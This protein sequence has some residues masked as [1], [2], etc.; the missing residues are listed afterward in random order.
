MNASVLIVDDNPINLKL[1]CEV[2]ELGGFSVVLARSAEEALTAIEAHLPE[3][4]LMDIGLPGMDGLTLTR[5]L[6]SD[7][8]YCGLKIVAL[9]AFAMKGDDIKA[10]QAGCDGY[11]SKPINTRTFAAQVGAY[12]P[13]GPAGP[14][15]AQGSST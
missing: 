1:T 8:R 11:I 7:S 12:F 6:K 10:Q 14:R 3:L 15:P 4:V 9:T 2:L 13:S 5:R